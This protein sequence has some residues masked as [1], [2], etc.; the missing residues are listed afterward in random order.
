MSCLRSPS[1]VVKEPR[2]SKLATGSRGSRSG[3]AGGL[4]QL[5][6][7]KTD[8]STFAITPEQLADRLGGRLLGT[9]PE[10][11]VGVATLEQAQP[12]H[13]AWVAT[14]SVLDRL[15]SSKA[16]VVVLPSTMPA[17]SGRCIVQVD[18]PESAIISLLHLFNPAKKLSP[19]GVHSAAHVDPSAVIDPT[20]SIAAG[21]VIAANAVV[22]QN[23][24]LHPGVVLGE[25]VSIGS[26]CELR[27][28]VV[29]ERGCV[30]GD[31]VIIHAST[32]I[33]ADG[34]GYIFRDGNHIKIP[35]IG[36]VVIEDD[37]EIGANSCI[38]RAR[39]G[40]T[41]IGR[42]TKIDNHVQ[43]AHNCDIGE[44]VVI[45]G[46]TG[47]AGSTE[48]GDYAMI[49]GHVGIAD[50]LRIGPG[51]R[52]AAKSGVSRHVQAGETVRGYPAVENDRYVR[53][54]I[55]LRRLPKLLEKLDPSREIEQS[56]NDE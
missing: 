37:V 30:I 25:N 32:T 54:Q 15:G 45:A 48:I 50:H 52:I 5:L 41:R 42:G 38:D 51:A 20:A 55:A 4:E 13:V 28:N 10:L 47:I 8:G 26:D 40:V 31:R 3:G 17:P 23:T 34:F 39:T 49:A 18:D 46:M 9:G 33:G 44:H 53:E 7:A 24:R 16:G 43:I 2:S 14:S 1:V 35:Q 19:A 29:V 27:A 21:V 22:G 12:D 56:A 6:M 36:T 11:I